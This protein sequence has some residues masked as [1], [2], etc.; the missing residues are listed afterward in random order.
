MTS[1][2]KYNNPAGSNSLSLPYHYEMV[3][4]A[5]RVVPFKKA[6]Q[7]VS[8]GKR[9]LESGTGSA[10]LSILAAK[11]GAKKV[12]AVEMDPLVAEFA[13]ENITK[14][15]FKDRI[16]LIRKNVMEVTLAD[17]DGEKVDVVIA[18]NLSTWE[19]TE[20]QIPIMNHVNKHLAKKNAARI[21]ETLYNH[22]ELAETQYR[23]EN[24]VDIRTHFFGFTGVKK[25]KA[26]S[27]KTLYATVDLS[28]QNSLRVRG[29]VKVKIA[30]KGILNSLRL[31]SPLTVQP[32]IRFEMSDS[33]M[34][35]VI[36]PLKKDL[37]VSKGDTVE[38]RI[39][40]S[41]YTNWDKVNCEAKIV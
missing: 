35:A 6:I 34:P 15:G 36:I 10:I 9:V 2:I 39:N 23:F 17:L 11:A 19:V 27:T 32:G 38:L 30:Q 41:Y 20:P 25:P 22:V 18:E 26:L 40:Y 24:V 7:K 28:K 8:K 29:M 3:S 33:L 16:K 13:Q 1:R 31:T 14:S 21:H 5:K 4:D 12:Y 37:T